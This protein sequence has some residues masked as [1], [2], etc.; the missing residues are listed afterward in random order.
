[1]TSG[2]AN[3]ECRLSRLNEPNGFVLGEA[4]FCAGGEI[5]AADLLN[6]VVVSGILL[7]A[8]DSVF[9]HCAPRRHA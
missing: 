9:F 6:P 8:G 3:H 1:M 4:H 5:D 7:L 2:I